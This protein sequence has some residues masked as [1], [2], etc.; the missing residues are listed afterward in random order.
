PARVSPSVVALADGLLRGMAAAKL[1]VGAF[2]LL[3]VTTLAAGAGLAVFQLGAAPPDAP[4]PAGPLL[5]DPEAFL[6]PPV[7]WRMP[8]DEQVL[9][10]AYA[11][12]G[13]VVA[14]AGADGT[15]QLCDARTGDV[16]HVLAG[17]AG[18]VTCL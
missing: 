11:A 8:I 3:G 5:N 18:M 13:D 15:V 12:D 1:K 16:L 2:L 6:A 14:L 10:L 7:P 17:H 4:V 9:A